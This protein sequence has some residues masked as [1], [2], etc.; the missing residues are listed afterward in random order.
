MED[1][2]DLKAARQAEPIDLER[3]PIRD[4]LTMKVDRS[5]GHIEPPADQ[6]EQRRFAGAVRSDDRVTFAD[7]DREVDPA[8]DVGIA[9]SLAHSNELERVRVSGREEGAHVGL[10]RIQSSISIWISSQR[11]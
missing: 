7:R 6:I 3:S 9:E 5:R 11:R 1:V 4:R 8:N 2:G 10:S